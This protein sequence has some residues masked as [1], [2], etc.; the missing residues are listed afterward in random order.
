MV[1]LYN[2]MMSIVKLANG[3]HTLNRGYWNSNTNDPL[4]AQAELCTLVG[5]FGDF[6]SAKLLVDIGSGLSDPAFHWKT[7]YDFLN[8][9]CL[10]V[11]TNL[12]M[13]ALNKNRNIADKKN[14][15]ISFVNAT[16]MVLPF[17]NNSVNRI[18]MLETIHFF[19]PL[20]LLIQ[21]CKRVLE[22]YGIFVIAT[23]IKT[24]KRTVLADLTR[25]GILSL[26][27]SSENY[28]K[29]YLLSVIRNNGFAIDEVLSI[30]SH[31]FEQAADYYVGNRNSLREKIINEYPSIIETI[32]YRSILKTKDAYRKGLIDYVLI[33]CKQL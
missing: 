21:E 20:F 26:I 2:Y 10:D 30:G 33:R 19:K 22:P 12:L 23:P 24:K 28:E 13:A 8:I 17:A 29:D 7:I 32:L 6:Y 16:G 18:I 25:F 31:V 15:C 4:Q 27:F 14:N 11:N 3:G 1:N 5:K 9:I